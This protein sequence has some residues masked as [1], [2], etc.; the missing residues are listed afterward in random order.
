MFYNTIDS[1]NSPKLTQSLLTGHTSG[2]M[3]MRSNLQDL[4][5]VQVRQEISQKVKLPL[6]LM[7]F[8]GTPQD[9]I[10]HYRYS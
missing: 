2:A 9:I 10:K 7:H 4:M 1:L 6:R 5:Q 3:T 8:K